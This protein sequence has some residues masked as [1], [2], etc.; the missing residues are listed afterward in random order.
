MSLRIRLV[1]LR[2]M[3]PLRLYRVIKFFE[4]GTIWYPVGVTRL[5]SEEDVE[6]FKEELRKRRGIS[7]DSLANFMADHWEEIEL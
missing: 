2:T 5:W 7:A 6:N 1:G 3:K 4:M